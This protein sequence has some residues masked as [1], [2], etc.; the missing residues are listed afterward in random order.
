MHRKAIMK[1]ALPVS[2][3][4]LAPHFGHAEAFAIVEV[5]VDAKSITASC[6]LEPP[7]HQP[8]VLPRWLVAQGVDVV[9]A[10][11]LGAHAQTLLEQHGVRVIAGAPADTPEALVT[12]CLNG[13]LN[14]ED[15]ICDHLQTGSV[16]GGGGHAHHGGCRR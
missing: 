3:G 10:Q 12:A 16:E 6:L 5:A 13:T 14:T 8:G 15:N 1:I 2:G 11:G 7:A 4:R 9:I